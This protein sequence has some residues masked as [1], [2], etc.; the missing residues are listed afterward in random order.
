[1][2]DFIKVSEEEKPEVVHMPGSIHCPLMSFTNGSS[3]IHLLKRDD[4]LCFVVDGFPCREIPWWPESLL[5]ALT[6]GAES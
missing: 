4:R 1:M 3:M 6:E 5:K 2:V